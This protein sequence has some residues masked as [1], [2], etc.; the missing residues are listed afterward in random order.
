MIAYKIFRPHTRCIEAL[1]WSGTSAS[2]W[3][4]RQGD[5]IRIL[6]AVKGLCINSLSK[7]IMKV[8]SEGTSK[9]S[10]AVLQN[11]WRICSWMRLVHFQLSVVLFWINFRYYSRSTVHG[12]LVLSAGKIRW[13]PS[14]SQLHQG[15][16][17]G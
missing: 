8:V 5:H 16:L 4:S 11:G 3:I 7:V 13:S 9:N 17:K 14:L 10:R 2:N 1:W 15:M 12:I 6:G